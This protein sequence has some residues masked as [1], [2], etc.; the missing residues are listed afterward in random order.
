M[1]KRKKE[2]VTMESAG[3]RRGSECAVVSEEK[4]EEMANSLQ[5][6]ERG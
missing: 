2:D 6:R 5:L 1:R 4:E 3:G